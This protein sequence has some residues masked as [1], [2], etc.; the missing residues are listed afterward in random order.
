[1][2]QPRS[3]EA[4]MAGSFDQRGSAAKEV[5]SRPVVAAVRLFVNQGGLGAS[6]SSRWRKDRGAGRNG[7]RT[8]V[9]STS[10]SS[11]ALCTTPMPLCTS[12]IVWPGKAPQLA[13]AVR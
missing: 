8:T 11:R 12:S 7:P 3:A 9:R 2:V 13:C 6:E 4:K 1:V 5:S 10:S